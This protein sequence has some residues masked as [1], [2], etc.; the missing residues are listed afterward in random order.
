[1]YNFVGE[2]LSLCIK[3]KR[4]WTSPDIDNIAST[5]HSHPPLSSLISTTQRTSC[6]YLVSCPSYK[7]ACRVLCAL[8]VYSLTITYT[9]LIVAIAMVGASIWMAAAFALPDLFSSSSGGHYHGRKARSR[10]EGTGEPGKNGSFK[11]L[12][13]VKL[14]LFKSCPVKN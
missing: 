13:C 2:R 1:M 11:R 8:C 3:S 4:S 6:N 9:S 5:T 14:N 12:L 7:R 10:E